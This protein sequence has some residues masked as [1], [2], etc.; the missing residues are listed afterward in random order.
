MRFS[1][2]AIVK[3]IEARIREEERSR[4]DF[5]RRFFN[6]VDRSPGHGPNGA[7]WLW[8]GH[9]NRETGYGKFCL[10]G[11]RV[12]AHVAAYL[13]S[14]RRLAPGKQVLHRCDFPSCVRPDHLWSGTPRQ[15]MLDKV[16]KG[17]A[18]R[19]ERCWTAKLTEEN[20]RD[21]RRIRV[22][23]KPITAIARMFKVTP[24]T[25]ADIVYGRTWAHVDMEER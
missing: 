7:C 2:G 15:N 13:I 14:G 3:R 22:E 24:P 5:K 8:T 4:R 21:I 19:G 16:L 18:V 17:R 6:L 25:V 12:A 11:R 20:V 23:G 10:P 1:P 9:I